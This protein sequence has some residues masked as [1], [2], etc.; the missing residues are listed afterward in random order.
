[1][2]ET[3]ASF[4]FIASMKI[5]PN[6]GIIELPYHY[7]SLNISCSVREL[8]SNNIDPLELKWF[9]NNHEIKHE[10]LSHLINKYPHHN[11]ATLTLHI[12]HLSLNDS[13]HFKCVYR[14]SLIISKDVQIIFTSGKFNLVL[15]SHMYQT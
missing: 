11:Q 12:K 5:Y 14:N 2:T 8:P 7:R 13:G 15:F 6:D 1:M 3:F 9:H 4:C 10:T